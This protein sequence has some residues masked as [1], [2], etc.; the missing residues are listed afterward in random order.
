MKIAEKLGWICKGTNFLKYMN[1]TLWKMEHK[2][3]LL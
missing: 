2:K 1:Q 3:V